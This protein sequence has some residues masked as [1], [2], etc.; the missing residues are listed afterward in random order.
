MSQ[1]SLS[2]PAIDS[3]SGL[4]SY[5]SKVMKIP[6][7]SEEEERVLAVRYTKDQD[8]SAAHQLVTSHLKLVVKIASGFRNYGLPM[9]DIISEGNIG[10]MKAVKKFDVD[11]G[12]RLSTYAMWWIKAQIQ[13]YVLRSWSLVKIGTTTAQKK[14]F[15]NLN[16]I[17]NKI[18]R[19]D[20]EYITDKQFGD[21]S[22]SLGVSESELKTMDQ[23]LSQGDVYMYDNIGGEEEEKRL[24]DILPDEEKIQDEILSEKEEK[25]HNYRTLYSAISDLKDREKHIILS[26][27][28]TD[29]PK[30]L[31]ALSKE[32]NIS[33]ERVRQIE[34]KALEKIKAY[35]TK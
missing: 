27:K 14:I 1:L 7:L 13:E 4:R 10:L 31:D 23:R 11:K 17:K 34:A 2:L 16:K 33:K 22:N 30:T 15:F 29:N 20:Q 12:F 5:L 21:I 6:V 25:D 3:D 18:M 19:Y 24:I 32:Y 9:M 28:L 8:I 35:F 26:R